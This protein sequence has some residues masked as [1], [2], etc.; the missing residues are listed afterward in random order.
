M[1]PQDVFFGFMMVTN[2]MIMFG[3]VFGLKIFMQRGK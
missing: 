1:I 3:A 2:L